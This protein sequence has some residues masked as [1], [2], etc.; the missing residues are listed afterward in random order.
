MVAITVDDVSKMKVADLK[1]ELKA[2]G[3]SDEGKKNELQERLEE[4]LAADDEVEETEEESPKKAAKRKSVEFTG[5]DDV[6]EPEEQTSSKYESIT[7]PAEKDETKGVKTAQE[8]S[9][10]AKIAARVARWGL[11][12]PPAKKQKES[13]SETK[14]NKNKK[15]KVDKRG[16]KIKMAVEE[17]DLEKLKSRAARFGD[18]CPKDLTELEKK[19]ARAEKFKN[20]TSEEE[21]KETNGKVEETVTKDES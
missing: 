2:L 19:V 5:S 11:V 14:E 10:E 3:L 20:G 21:T 1:K 12:E 17:V 16:P 18:A 8:L 7:A 6:V 13:A 9:D 15:E 4:A